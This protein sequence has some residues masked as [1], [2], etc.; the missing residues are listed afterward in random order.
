VGDTFR[1]RE[2]SYRWEREMR[3]VRGQRYC[4][5][6]PFVER[7]GTLH[8]AGEEWTFIESMFC[9]YDSAQV[10]I[11]R[12]LDGRDWQIELEDDGGPPF[13]IVDK[14]GE[15]VVALE[16][17]S[18]NSRPTASSSESTSTESRSDLGQDSNLNSSQS[19]SQE[20]PKRP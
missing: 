9:P 8:P 4:V 2:A 13:S 14:F 1:H 7:D 11:V 6:K 16:P 20:G 3:L 19:R 18:P 17:E 15:Y 12:G 5:A 10:V